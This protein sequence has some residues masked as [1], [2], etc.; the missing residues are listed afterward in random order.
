V[1]AGVSR[2][3]RA[4][5]PEALEFAPDVGEA[6]LTELAGKQNRLAFTARMTLRE[7]RA[8]NLSFS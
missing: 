6:V 4:R 8:G 2:E 7:W 3:L 1:V 5:G